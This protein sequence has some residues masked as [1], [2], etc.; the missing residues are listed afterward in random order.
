MK[1]LACILFIISFLCVEISTIADAANVFN[2]P[3]IGSMVS[4]SSS[5]SPPIVMGIN[6]YPSNP[7][8]FDFIIDKGNF[9]L[10]EESFKRESNKL[11]KYFL[12][13]LTIPENEMWV[14][15]SPYEKNRIIPEAFGE[16]IMG[17]D[18]LALDYM[19]KQLSS[20]L[21]HPGQDLGSQF[22]DRVY[23]K[24]QEKFGTSEI[25]INTFNKIWIVPEK[26]T[27]Y[28]HGQGALI[29]HSHLKVMLEEDYLALETNKD[30]TKH[31]LGDISEDNLDIISGISG[32]VVREI[33]IP[34]IEK[35]VNEGKT[36]ANLRQI[37]HSMLLAAWYKNSLKESF[38][39]QTYVNQ[40]KTKGV[41]TLT[42]GFKQKIYNQY[43]E[44]FKKGVF[45]FVKED[46]DPITQK[47]IPRKYF[48]G[49]V[50]L[51][52]DQAMISDHD[53]VKRPRLRDQILSAVNRF[54]KTVKVRFGLNSVN[55][56]DYESLT[57]KIPSKIFGDSRVPNDRL[58]RDFD[59]YLDADDYLR[60][61]KNTSLKETFTPEV[62]K[63]LLND[64]SLRAVFMIKLDEQK[65]HVGPIEEVDDDILSEI[66]GVELLDNYSS[67]LIGNAEV[68]KEAVQKG[69]NIIVGVTDR[70]SE[71]TL[72]SNYKV[73]NQR[74]VYFPLSDGSWLGIKGAGDFL[75]EN[76]QTTYRSG[77]HSQKVWGLASKAEARRAGQVRQILKEGEFLAVQYLGFR[78]LNV[79]TDGKGGLM[80]TSDVE[81]VESTSNPGEQ[82]VPV[83]IFNRV[84]SP[85]RTVKFPQL[86]NDDFGL[87]GL[88]NNI[89][90]A[91]RNN[92]RSVPRTVGDVMRNLGDQL[93]LNFAFRH[94][95]GLY[96][97]TIHP[98]DFTFLGEES[99]NEEFVNYDKILQKVMNDKSSEYS[100]YVLE[101]LQKHQINIADFSGM[102]Y[103]MI[104]LSIGVQ[105]RD[106][107][108]GQYSSME[109]VQIFFK[110]YF[111]KLSDKNLKVWMDEFD[112]IEYGQNKKSISRIFQLI[113]AHQRIY[114]F[115]PNP[116]GN[117]E[118]DAFEVMLTM[119]SWLDYEIQKRNSLK[120]PS[121]HSKDAVSPNVLR[122]A[123]YLVPGFRTPR[124]GEP[125]YG[126]YRYPA[127]DAKVI[128]RVF[129]NFTQI[130]P[131]FEK[132]KL[133]DKMIFY[134]TGKSTN[135]D[136]VASIL[137][138][139]PELNEET[140]IISSLLY[141]ARVSSKYN[142]PIGMIEHLF[143][144]KVDEG[145]YENV[146]E[147]SSGEQIA[148][149]FVS[150]EIDQLRE[151]DEVTSPEI[152]SELKS[153]DL[154]DV[155][156]LKEVDYAM[157]ATN[158]FI[159]GGIDLNPTIVDMSINKQGAGLQLPAFQDSV[160]E[161]HIDGF[162]PIIIDIIPIKNI[163]PMI[164]L[165][166]P[167]LMYSSQKPRRR[168]MPCK[169]LRVRRECSA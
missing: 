25:P 120:M 33:L 44:A 26:A 153:I 20:S 169:E 138:V 45:D 75:D 24:A 166:P 16:T 152:F 1:Q 61:F 62:M 89:A 139:L 51:N 114:K 14:N 46:Y 2:L 119:Q 17:R 140:D 109:L 55:F 132:E 3:E 118:R 28:E 37:Y 19:L 157:V 130:L 23:E 47:L 94:N 85:H 35:E 63:T 158:D 105:V 22:W 36:F 133:Q 156:T 147:M 82:I 99:D 108:K 71:E 96:K 111:S 60:E 29:V 127:F 142:L 10:D 9:D 164:G 42:K 74:Q 72:I 53:A 126:D 13:S 162:V 66:G 79:L 15:L 27:V 64:R 129:K 5:C 41:E 80:K 131:I 97:L 39:S 56:E 68:A 7:L 43:L 95:K 115:H 31:G 103:L 90:I 100:P 87:K 59:L 18:L 77:P 92:R 73:A 107:L 34:E 8:Q 154:G 58:V 136:A 141:I 121:I 83:L 67:F 86:L 104:Y 167:D 159:K 155:E 110:T 106:E 149:D 165:L 137:K 76:A 101:F 54:K 49:G 69:S 93:A 52:G 98:Q 128:Q 124:E 123:R 48:S 122:E 50:E 160:E 113:F 70:Y 102:V 30:S 78:P 125:G 6:V 151:V 21:M 135:R 117:T 150:R 12:A 84:L 91:S 81:L 161:F 134:V 11:I 144:R 146:K 143:S 112:I 168:L 38:L 148:F 57:F 32:E 4:F 163:L 40:K 145:F 65:G 116:S 88:V